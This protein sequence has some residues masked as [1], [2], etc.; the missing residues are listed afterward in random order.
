MR[1]LILAIG[2]ARGAEAEGAAEYIKRLGTSVVVS[3]FAASKSLPA[4]ETQ[5]AEA[6]L[7]IKA[8][9]PKSFVV[10]C[11][12]RGKDMTSR[13]FAAKLSAWQDRGLSDLVFIIGGADG[14]TD[15]VRA[16]A[17]FTLG[18]GRLTWP[19]R[20]VRVMLLEQI[21]RARQIIAGHPY[22]RD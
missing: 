22:H 8:I 10:L 11:D 6:Q 4:A 1:T 12:E 2:K 16:K 19:H 3:E 14:V 20:L 17:N 5:K 7:L 15:D 9:P 21:Y 13:E 18:F